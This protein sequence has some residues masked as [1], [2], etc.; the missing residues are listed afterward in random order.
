ML[1]V[2][3]TTKRKA[4]SFIFI[5][6]MGIVSLFSDMTHEGARS[7]YGVYLHIAGASATVSALFFGWLFS[8]SLLSLWLYHYIISFQIIII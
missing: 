6:I 1:Q 5:L 2:N 7:I 4:Y 3:N 8:L